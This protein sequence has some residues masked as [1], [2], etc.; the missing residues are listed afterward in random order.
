MVNPQLN[1]GNLGIPNVDQSTERIVNSF[2]NNMKNRLHLY[3]GNGHSMLNTPVFVRSPKLS[4]IQR[5]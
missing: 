5:G 2:M 3:K 4:Y 1:E